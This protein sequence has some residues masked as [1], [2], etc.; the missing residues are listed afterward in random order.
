MAGERRLRGLGARRPRRGAVTPGRRPAGRRRHRRRRR[1]RCRHRRGARPPGCLRRHDGP[2]RVARRHASALPAPEETTAGRIVAAGGSARATSVSVTDADA[3]R[4]LFEELGRLDA[5]VNVAG[6]TRPTSFARGSE[7]D[8]RDVLDVHLDGY[9]NVLAAALPI[10]AAAGHGRILGVTS[11]SGWRPADTGAYGCAKRAVAALTWQLGRRAPPGVVVNAMSPIA[12]TRMVT[13]ALASAPQGKAGRSS[14]TGGLSLG[15]MPAARGARPVRRPPRGRGPLVVPRPGDLRRRV[16][17]RGDRANPACSRWSAPATSPRSPTVLDAVVAGALR[18]R[19]GAAGDQRREQPAVRRRSSTSAGRRRCRRRRSARARSSPT[20]RSSAAAVHGRARGSRHRAAP[21]SRSA[22]GDRLRRAPPASP[23]RRPA[24]GRR[25]RGRARRVRRRDRVDD[26]LGA[27]AGRA[28]RHRRRHP[29]RRRAG[30][31]PSPTTPPPPSVRSGWSPSP[32]PPPR[33][34][35]PGAGVGPARP[36]GRGGP[37]TIASSAFAV[38]V[39]GGDGDL[40]RRRARRPPGVQPRGAGALRRRAG[41]R[42]RL[43][44]SPQPPASQRQH[45]LRWSRRPRLVRRRAAR[46]IAGEEAR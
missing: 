26:R 44:R 9:L 23:R 41:R 15:S 32:T 22:V 13:A 27:G 24:A 3:V 36:R 28:R 25:G 37:R 18:A 11:G 29:R 8:W 43:V 33:R 17:G 6:I 21:T 5:V 19:R 46:G 40:R 12:V 38:S 30:P 31:G 1:D 34:P 4:G 39:E 20:D 42:P 2:A 16:R 10:M 14:A 7:E 45:H 35:Q